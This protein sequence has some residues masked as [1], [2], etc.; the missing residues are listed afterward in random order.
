MGSGRLVIG[1][2]KSGDAPPLRTPDSVDGTGELPSGSLVDTRSKRKHKFV[3]ALI[4][5]QGVNSGGP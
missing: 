4:R 1:D 2:R 3:I 5:V